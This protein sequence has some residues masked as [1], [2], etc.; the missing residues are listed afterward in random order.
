MADLCDVLKVSG[1]L[2]GLISGVASVIVSR[3]ATKK[4]FKLPLQIIAIAGV[5][6][7]GIT[8]FIDALPKPI[9]SIPISNPTVSFTYRI[10]SGDP[11]IQKWASRLEADSRTE[12]T[13]PEEKDWSGR[14]F[15]ATVVTNTVGGNAIIKT[16]SN[17]GGNFGIAAAPVVPPDIDYL[18]DVFGAFAVVDFQIWIVPRGSAC[19]QEPRLYILASNDYEGDGDGSVQI[20]WKPD[21]TLT[22]RASLRIVQERPQSGLSNFD[23]FGNM[24]VCMGLRGPDGDKLSSNAVAALSGPLRRSFHLINAAVQSSNG[25]SITF[26]NLKEDGKAFFDQIY[27]IDGPTMN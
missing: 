22:L 18:Y 4:R 27:Y 11:S 24:R 2:I 19:D 1:A 16:F 21:S 17:A 15:R 20:E 6:T 10:D 9:P 7:A 26:A 23:Q 3:R 13:S 25:Q 5:L 12:S 14:P 8:Q